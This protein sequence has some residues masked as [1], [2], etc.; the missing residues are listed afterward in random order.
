VTKLRAAPRICWKALIFCD[1]F[2][3]YIAALLVQCLF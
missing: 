1:K 3:R 2:A